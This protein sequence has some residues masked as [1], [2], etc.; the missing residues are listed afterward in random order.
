M[1]KLFRIFETIG[2]IKSIN[3]LRRMGH[4]TVAN[5][6]EADYAKTCI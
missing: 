5:R 3:E 2:Y 4:Y 1:K 6:L